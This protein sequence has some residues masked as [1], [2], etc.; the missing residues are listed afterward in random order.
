MKKPKFNL[1]NVATIVACF[2]V[3]LMLI[4][5]SC[6]KED[7]KK[8]DGGGGGGGITKK[9]APPA[10][11]Q[12]EWDYLLESVLVMRYKFTSNNIYIVQGT[13]D[14]VFAEIMM[15]NFIET[16][17][18]FKYTV[19]EE[20]NTSSLYEI[21]INISG[22][23]MP[24]GYYSYAFKKGDGTY[25][26]LES[27]VNGNIVGTT[28]KLN[29]VE[30]GGGEETLT[31]IK[32]DKLEIS[33]KVGATANLTL[34][35]LPAAATLP[36]CNFSSDDETIAT[37][38]STGKVTAVAVGETTITAVTNDGKFSAECTVK[39]TDNGGGGDDLYRDPYLNF[40]G[41]ITAVKNYETRELFYEDDE[42]L[43]FVGENADVDDVGYYFADNMLLYILVALNESSDIETRAKNFLSKKYV[44]LG[45][46]NGEHYF[47]TSDG[48]I[49][50][51]LFNDEEY[52]LGWCVDYWDNTT[53][54]KAAK[55]MKK[56]S[57][58]N[59]VKRN[60]K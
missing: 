52:G 11:I 29:K 18:G 38:N 42:M 7:K 60:I 12:G 20:K 8:D 23:I 25:I 2:A 17:E 14:V 21:R 28:I 37:V 9:L 45:T 19:K 22:T 46:Y 16:V 39:V 34:L 40:G 59:L 51:S 48:T 43:F 5:T 3:S 33:L 15:K 36:K 47:S 1:K 24:S 58:Q 10:W 56:Y 13:T 41:S 4:F 53:E 6:T 49:G 32:F 35:P 27:S 26:E 57:I 55:K 50:I 44:Y 31:G 30:G 54:A